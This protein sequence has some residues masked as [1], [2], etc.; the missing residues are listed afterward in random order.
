MR[1]VVAGASGIRL[2]SAALFPNPFQE[3]LS[4]SIAHN[5]PEEDVDVT[6]R[7]FSVSGQLI[8]TFNRTY[9]TSEPTLTGTIEL[10][11]SSLFID[12]KIALYLYDIQIRSIQDKS[13]ARQAGKLLRLP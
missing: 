7:L 1:F 9:Y 13:V 6:V 11:A 3:R 8:H 12:P 2:T 10:N 4:F 5:R